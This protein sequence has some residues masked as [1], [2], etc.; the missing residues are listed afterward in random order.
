MEDEKQKTLL[1]AT[2]IS[3]LPDYYRRD[4]LERDDELLLLELLLRDELL[5]ELVDTELLLLEELLRELPLDTLLLLEELLRELPLDTLLLLEELLLRETPLFDEVPREVDDEVE[6][7]LS[8][9]TVLPE[10]VRRVVLVELLLPVRV[11]PVELLLR[12]DV[13][14]PEEL[15]RRVVVEVPVRSVV[16]V[17]RL[18]VVL[19]ARL[20]PVR[21]GVS[22][23]TAVRRFSSEST[24]TTRLLASREGTLT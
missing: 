23:V 2:H 4:P 3:L 11:V 22:D 19:P 20:D 6:R 18:L 9:F 5:R 15:P 24:L 13:P 12:V 8:V 16:E 21:V 10:V 7:L 14:T 17:E 1:N